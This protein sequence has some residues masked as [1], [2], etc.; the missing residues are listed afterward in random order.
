MYILTV[1]KKNLCFY[2]K[3]CAETFQKIYGGQIKAL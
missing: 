2:V 1:G 3:A